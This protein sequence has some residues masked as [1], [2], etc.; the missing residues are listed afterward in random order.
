MG[1]GQWNDS[2]QI[3]FFFSYDRGE[4]KKEKEKENSQNKPGKER[5]RERENDDNKRW[6]EVKNIVRRNFDSIYRGK[7]RLRSNGKD[8][9]F[10]LSI[11]IR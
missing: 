7:K 3:F 6:K 4:G 1:S 8:L 2:V 10:R 9:I 11:V 5:E